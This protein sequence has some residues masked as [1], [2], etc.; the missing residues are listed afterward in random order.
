[1]ILCAIPFASGFQSKINVYICVKWM[2]LFV[3][4][5]LERS[6]SSSM[7]S[8]FI[9]CTA[10]GFVLAQCRSH[11]HVC[12]SPVVK[13]NIQLKKSWPKKW[14]LLYRLSFNSQTLTSQG[15]I[16]I[17]KSQVQHC[18]FSFMWKW[19][20]V[21]K[22]VNNSEQIVKGKTKNCCNQLY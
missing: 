2:C 11:V 6:I 13:V 3:H 12:I 1:M 20:K 22:G 17:W 16:L 21:L 9:K 19:Y 4:H 10:F 14:Y 15:G 7:Q 18:C 5:F 8:C